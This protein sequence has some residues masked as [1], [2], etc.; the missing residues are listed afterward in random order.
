MSGIARLIATIKCEINKNNFRLLNL[1]GP[2]FSL[3]DVL[4][5]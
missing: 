1:P 2:D 4:G 3:V 5:T